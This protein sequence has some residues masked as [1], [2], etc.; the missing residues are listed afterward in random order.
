MEEKRT[1]T[2]PIIP[3]DIDLNSLKE[4]LS[5]LSVD[6]DAMSRLQKQ[7]VIKIHQAIQAHLEAL[8]EAKQSIK[9]H[10]FRLSSLADECG[11][12]RPTLY[13]N[14]VLN[15]LVVLGMAEYDALTPNAVTENQKSEIEALKIE[16]EKLIASAID[17]AKLK[18][19]I[20]DLQHELKILHEKTNIKT[21]EP[22]DF[23]NGFRRI[24]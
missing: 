21:N 20:E 12:S 19:E 14:P 8:R 3:A 15:S 17:T 23:T 5:A 22:K 16:N 1:V 11:I 13:N 2:A 4:K 18:L 6:F 9:N 24:K 10:R 7:Q